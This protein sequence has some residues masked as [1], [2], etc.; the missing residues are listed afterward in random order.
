MT[1]PIY[2]AYDH[3][4]TRKRIEEACKSIKVELEERLE[5]YFKNPKAN[6]LKPNASRCGPAKIWKACWSSAV[7][8][9]SKTIRATSINVSRV[10]GLIPW[11]II[12]PRISLLLDR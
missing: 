10:K 3:A 12:F 2:P 8:L 5:A 9:A 11:S 4:S 7:A 1:Y 6:S